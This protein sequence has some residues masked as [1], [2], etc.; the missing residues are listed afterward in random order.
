MKQLAVTLLIVVCGFI[1]WQAWQ[2]P[3]TPGQQSSVRASIPQTGD[4]PQQMWRVVTHRMVWKQA[5]IELENR[6]QESGI[7]MERIM[8][9]EPVELHA[10]DDP[11]TFETE[12][13]AYKVKAMWREKGVEADVLKREITY[14]VGLGRFFLIDYAERMQSRLKQIGVPYQYERRTV[15]IPAYRFASDSMDKPEAEKL[16][17]TLQNMGVGSPVL[18]PE[19]R[20]AELYGQESA[21]SDDADTT[22]S[23]ESVQTQ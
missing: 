2:P 7:A 16:W 19:S 14:G 8:R 6:L 10:F 15:V 18:I 13:E 12:A 11:G 9:K 1:A 21:P 23:T 5:V 4:Q 17:K 20:F 22:P 3:A